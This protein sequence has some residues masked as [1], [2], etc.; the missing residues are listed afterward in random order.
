MPIRI[1]HTADNHIGM[2][3]SSYSPAAR[4]RLIQERFDSLQQIVEIGNAEEVNYLVIA[5]DLFDT[6]TLKVADITKT[7]GI[8]KRFEGVVIIIPG[9][10]DF[11]NPQRKVCGQGLK[12]LL[13]TKKYFYYQHR[14]FLNM[15]LESKK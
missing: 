4:E 8:L 7:A 5:G 11:L 13:M 2:K 15:R 10:H 1:L 3:F 14:K 6:T 9:N 12:I